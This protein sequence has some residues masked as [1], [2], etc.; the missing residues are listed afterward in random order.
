LFIV[1]KIPLRISEILEFQ[2]CIESIKGDHSLISTTKDG[3]T[4]K[5]E[6]WSSEGHLIKGDP[7]EG[8]YISSPIRVGE[9]LRPEER[10][11]YYIEHNLLNKYFDDKQQI[12]KQA[13]QKKESKA[14][15]EAAFTVCGIAIVACYGLFIGL[16]HL[17]KLRQAEKL[18][19]ADLAQQEQAR[20]EPC[21]SACAA[22]GYTMQSY[23]D[24]LCVCDRSKLI[25][26]VH[27]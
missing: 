17:Q 7:N 5:H 3:C 24:S 20:V 8:N 2:V 27:Q 6:R 16:E 26:N 22:E 25:V 18:Q 1:E 19:E 10:E 21:V 9:G 13:L 4:W 11:N 12:L 23:R 15:W 14:F